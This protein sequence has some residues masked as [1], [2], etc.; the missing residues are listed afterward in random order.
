MVFEF[1]E[2]N[3]LTS[4]WLTF[5]YERMCGFCRIYWLLEHLA[6]GCRGPPD[7]SAV[8]RIGAPSGNPNPS[9]SANLSGS[10]LNPFQNIG[11]RP[12]QTRLAP[13]QPLVF[14]QVV[15]SPRVSVSREIVLSTKMISGTKRNASSLMEVDLGKRPRGPPTM[16]EVP[17]ADLG[18]VLDLSLP[19]FAGTLI[20]SPLKKRKVGRPE[21]YKNKPK[22]DI[23]LWKLKINANAKKLTTKKRIQDVKRVLELE[24]TPDM[25]TDQEKVELEEPGETS[26]A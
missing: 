17:N 11:L 13:V 7:M 4:A 9:S 2:G 25:Q 10:T 19:N 20:V 6:S 5:K 21:G 24:G 1:G 26:S 14:K 8:V 15:E 18:L 12:V 16:L 23:P 3:D 22:E